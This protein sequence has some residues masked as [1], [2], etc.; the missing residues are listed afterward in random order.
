MAEG[1]EGGFTSPSSDDLCACSIDAWYP[2][3]RSV[4]IRSA[5]IPL[6]PAF[7]AYLLEDGDGIFL[8]PP[9]PARGAADSPGWTDDEDS[10]DQASEPAERPA[11]GFDGKALFAQIDAA[12]AKL[13]G[14]AFPKMNWSSPRDSAWVLGGSLR[15]VCA[16]DVVSLLKCSQHVAHDLTEHG[17]YLQPAAGGGKPSPVLALRR[18]CNLHPE[19]ELRCFALGGELLALSQRDRHTHYAHLAD[20]RD[21]T[22]ARVRAFWSASLGAD[23]EFGGRGGRA[24]V[25]DLYIDS[26]RKVHLV[27]IGPFA[28]ATTDPL[29]FEWGELVDLASRASAGELPEPP[30]LRLV[31][32]GGPGV[33]PSSRLYAGVPLELQ[34]GNSAQLLG[35]GTAGGL[36]AGAGHAA[37]SQQGGEVASAVELVRSALR[38]DG[39]ASRAQR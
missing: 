14:S 20:E 8:P 29:L 1:G 24:C 11:F 30:E 16:R 7:V 9:P 5:L 15:C 28:E 13:G 35:G 21:D 34:P 4:S 12:I 3:L 31:G 2:R 38:L 26:A 19:G 39:K 33:Q 6:P 25:A 17:A 32:A 23:P 18:W 27:D 37:A 22:V 10:V 36:A